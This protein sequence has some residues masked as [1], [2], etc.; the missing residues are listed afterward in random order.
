MVRA[1]LIEARQRK[2]MTQAQVAQ[3]IGLSR[4]SYTCIERGIRQPSLDV[5]L[6]IADI[7]GNN[8]ESLFLPSDD[9][10]SDASVSPTKQSA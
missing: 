8:V 2:N 5:A 4:S 9:A 7:L 10:S 1:R 6:R 3:A